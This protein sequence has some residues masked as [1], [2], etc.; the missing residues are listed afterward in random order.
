MLD[1]IWRRG[2][3]ML[4]DR[5][6]LSLSTASTGAREAYVEGC[7]LALT[8]YPGAARAYDRAL[9]ADPGFALAHAGQAQ[10]LMREGNVAAAR[11]ALAAAKDAAAHLSEREAGHIAFFQLV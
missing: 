3:L 8:F 11:A 2:F 10:V 1:E 9:A 4:T 6:G 7:D 5:Y